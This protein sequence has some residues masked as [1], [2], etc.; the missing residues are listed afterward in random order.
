MKLPRQC[1]ILVGGLGTRLGALTAET[2]KPL[3]ECGGRPFLAWVLRELVRFGIE[4][5]IL[6]A[7]YRSE[8]VEQFQN[9]L[10]RWVPKP[11]TCRVSVEPSPAGTA[12]ALCYAR[13]WLDDTFLMM[14]GDSWLDTNLARFFSAAG[15]TDAIGCVLLRSMQE[16]SRYGTAEVHDSRLV[17]FREQGSASGPG[18]IGAGMYIFEKRLLERFSP[19]SSLEKD[20]LP[21]LARQGELAAS[22]LDGYFIDIGVPS[23]YARAQHEL[24]QRLLRP[25]VFFDRDGVLNENLGWV[26]TPD[27]FRWIPGAKEALRRVADAGAH[28]FVV[29]NQAGVA[30]GFYT[31]EDVH[32]LQQHILE[33]LLESGATIDD[34]RFCPYHPEGVLEQYRRESDWRKPGAGMLL[35]LLRAWDIDPQRALLVG[36]MESD[37]QAAHAAHIEGHRYTGGNLLDLVE[38]LLARLT[39][40][41]TSPAPGGR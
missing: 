6:L 32:A 11:L 15:A 36:D 12:G 39:L 24:P 28:A 2:P 7:G 14:N 35:D 41:N 4:D 1:A 33:E 18:L 31:E 34:F 22:V 21:P 10:A 19:P 30:R 16:C 13:D 9:E 26:G 27:R 29:T 23:D 37:I 25:A 38:P 17:A 20:V 3:L 5:V 8:R 40:Q